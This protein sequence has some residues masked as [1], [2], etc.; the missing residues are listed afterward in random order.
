[1]V[2]SREFYATDDNVVM[3]IDIEGSPLVEFPLGELFDSATS[4]LNDDYLMVLQ[5]YGAQIVEDV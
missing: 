3:T 4:T 2:A 5:D 1:M